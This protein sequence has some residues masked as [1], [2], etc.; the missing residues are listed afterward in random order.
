MS[1]PIR[2][3]PVTSEDVVSAPDLY[4]S[5]E[6]REG[7]R[8]AIEHIVRTSAQ[9]GH[10]MA[11]H[12]WEKPDLRIEWTAEGRIQIFNDAQPRR[13]WWQR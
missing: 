1:T 5:T 3:P 7:K 6:T 9:Y 10:D 11:V 12:G 4:M 8:A 13:R 2:L